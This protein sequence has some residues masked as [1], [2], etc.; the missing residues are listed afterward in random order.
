[1]LYIFAKKY[2]GIFILYYIFLRRDALSGI[3]MVCALVF[4]SNSDRAEKCCE[5]RSC[6]KISNPNIIL[7]ITRSGLY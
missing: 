7:K 6:I 2:T 4:G 5:V 1:M 3:I